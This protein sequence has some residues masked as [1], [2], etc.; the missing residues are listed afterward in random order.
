MLLS[1]EATSV[2]L[3][4]LLG[5]I[6]QRRSLMTFLSFVCTCDTHRVELTYL[7]YGGFRCLAH[8]L[9]EVSGRFPVKDKRTLA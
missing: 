2:I 6:S 8:G 1:L 4:F 3:V 7:D 5:A 9:V